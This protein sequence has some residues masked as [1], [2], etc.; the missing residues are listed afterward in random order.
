MIYYYA[1]DDMY[2]KPEFWDRLDELS[3]GVYAKQKIVRTIFP[4]YTKMV[5]D[6]SPPFFGKC[7]YVAVKDGKHFL[8]LCVEASKAIGLDRIIFTP[9]SEKRE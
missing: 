3:N 4:V 7:I 8:E 1:I 6:E 9:L 2:N 5:L